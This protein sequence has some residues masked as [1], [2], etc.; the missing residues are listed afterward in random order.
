MTQAIDNRTC[1]VC[2][3]H[4]GFEAK[5]DAILKN[6]EA[7]MVEHSKLW[8]AIFNL[9]NRPPIWTTVIISLLSGGLGAVA[10]ALISHLG[11]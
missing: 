7:S 5:L 9:Q 4:S 10:T 11:N 3:H 6:Q 2:Q 8:D 1:D